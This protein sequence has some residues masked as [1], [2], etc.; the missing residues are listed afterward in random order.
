MDERTTRQGTGKSAKRL[1]TAQKV[2]TP[3]AL[4]NATRKPAPDLEVRGI[5]PKVFFSLSVYRNGFKSLAIQR[6]NRV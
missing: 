6:Y 4:Y 1:K 5:S 2:I 3:H